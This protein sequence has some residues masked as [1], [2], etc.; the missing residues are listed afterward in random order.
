MARIHVIQEEEAEGMLQ[1]VYQDLIQSRGKLAEV[2]K[3]QSLNPKTIISHMQLY[4]DIMYGQSPLKRW[5]REMIAVVV[6]VTN[7]CAYCTQHHAEALHIFWKDVDKMNELIDNKNVSSLEPINQLWNKLAKT[8]TAT[9]SSPEIGE[10]IEKLKNL[11]LDDRSILDATLVI[12]YFNFVNRIILG[13]GVELEADG[14]KG[15]KYE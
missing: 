2:H 8:I 14:G 10:T 15:Y 3:I 6:S 11:G 12:A 7:Q 13:L 9:P 5:Q 1:K 4:M